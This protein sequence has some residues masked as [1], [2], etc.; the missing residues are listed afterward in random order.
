[1]PGEEED[2]PNYSAES[3]ASVR[4]LVQA[5]AD[6]SPGTVESG[7]LRRLQTDDRLLSRYMRRKRG[8]VEQSV[9][10]IVD[11][12]QWRQKQ[13]IA[14]LSEREFPREFF[15]IGGLYIYRHDRQGEHGGR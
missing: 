15:E 8:N 13:S 14:T 7:D 6:A 10:F 2:C 1:M 5:Q 11:A 3:L 9:A 4:A 12:L